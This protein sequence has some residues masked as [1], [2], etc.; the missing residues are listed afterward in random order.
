MA[1]FLHKCNQ[2]H[3]QEI[4]GLSMAVSEAVTGSAQMMRE[5]REVD[6]RSQTIAAAAEEMVA[7]VR[8]I[9]HSSESATN[10]AAEAQNHAGQAKVKADQAVTT[11][12]SIARA[13]ADAAAKVDGLADASARIGDIVQQIEAIAKQ[14]NLL[15]LNATIEAARAGDAG[16]GFAVVATEVKNL[17][18]QTAKATED[19]RSRITHLRSEMAAI[20]SSMEE[21][22]EAVHKGQEVISATGQSM[23][24]VTERVAAVTDKIRDIAAILGQQ[25]EASAEIS[26]GIAAM[27]SENVKT[28]SGI[29]DTMDKADT[30]ITGAVADLAKLEIKDFTVHVAKSDHVIW[31]KR[32]AQILVGRLALKANELADHHQCRLGK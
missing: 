15:A 24:M 8:D 26:S 32:L 23:H 13:V 7:S 16:K 21:G 18:N 1:N 3:L 2:G 29:I 30:I 19:I 4:V 31:R 11:M 22:A 27:S 5:V 17:A 14:T 12:E 25:K 6:H 9:S 28:I 20:V 10:D